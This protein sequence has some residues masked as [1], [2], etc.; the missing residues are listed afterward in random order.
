MSKSR[1]SSRVAVL[2]Q[3]DVVSVARSLEEDFAR[4]IALFD[5]ELE[6]RSASS[7]GARSR[8]ADARSAAQRGFNVSQELSELLREVR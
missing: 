4:L 8:I 5:R 2:E 6:S 1:S 3:V 7:S